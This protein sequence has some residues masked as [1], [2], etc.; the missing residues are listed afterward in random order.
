[1][2]DG[3]KVALASPLFLPGMTEK[4]ARALLAAANAGY[5]EFP[6]NATTEEVSTS[7]GVARSTFEQHL[8]RAEHYVV[9]AMLP[10][11]RM[12][13]GMPR[14]EALEVY[15][16]FS[17][18][19]GLYVR[20]EVLGDHVAGVSLSKEPIPASTGADHPYL[21]RILEHIRTGEDD[22]QDIPLHLELSPFEREVLELL[23][24]IP[25]GATITYGEIAKRLG[26]PKAARAV[27][28]AV[29]RNP[30]IIVIP[31]HRVLPASGR[32]GNYSGEG[33]PETKRRLLERE[34]ARLA[35]PGVPRN[36]M[37]EAARPRPLA[38]SRT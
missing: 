3:A 10:I 38:R 19:L 23:R 27:G 18:E 31:C 8:N 9:R 36:P 28:N 26:H 20:L 22:L 33:G 21:A 11:V 17:R 35:A 34:G 14:D 5:Y 37:K 2:K 1:P 12:R 16:R 30:A 25:P 24:T 32:L 6:R 4:Q 13:A 29:A 15:S 7:L